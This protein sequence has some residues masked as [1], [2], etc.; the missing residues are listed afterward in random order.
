M[1]TTGDVGSDGNVDSVE[2]MPFNG[3]AENGGDPTPI[4][5]VLLEASSDRALVRLYRDPLKQ[6]AITTADEV[7]ALDPTEFQELGVKIGHRRPILKAAI[8]VSRKSRQCN[9]VDA[10]KENVVVQ[11]AAGSKTLK[12]GI[13]EEQVVPFSSTSQG[14]AAHRRVSLSPVDQPRGITTESMVTPP[15]TSDTASSAPGAGAGTK[16]TVE[17]VVLEPIPSPTP[18]DLDNGF[19]HKEIDWQQVQKEIEKTE[20]EET[21]TATLLGYKKMTTMYN[22]FEEIF[23]FEKDHPDMILFNFIT[24]IER[25]KSLK[26]SSK[27]SYLKSLMGLFNLL[28]YQ[29]FLS[30]T[31][32]DLVK[33]RMEQYGK[34]ER[35]QRNAGILNA[36]KAITALDSLH[37]LNSIIM[38]NDGSKYCRVMMLTESV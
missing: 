21:S 34:I 16:P 31:S 2:K 14:A 38:Q 4:T 3:N 27:R 9:D 6:E 25:N 8:Q 24:T 22:N 13:H 10:N 32:I 33:K 26:P 5:R 29:P 1:K 19:R 36:N 7:A 28:K 30:K 11:E 17:K 37:L 23:D 15:D 20:A 12:T 35:Q 18:R